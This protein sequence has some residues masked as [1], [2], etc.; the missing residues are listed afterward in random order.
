MEACIPHLLGLGFIVNQTVAYHPGHRQSYL[1][2]KVENA[3]GWRQS[4]VPLSALSK[5]PQAFGSE[6]TYQRRY[7]L[8]ALMGIA[9]DDDDGNA[10]ADAH[11]EQGER[12]AKRERRENREPRQDR[13]RQN[14]T[15]QSAQREPPPEDPMRVLAK[16]IRS[17]LLTAKSKADL[18]M[19]ADH[20]DVRAD[21]QRVL[22][23]DKRLH[24]WLVGEIDA[25]GAKLPAQ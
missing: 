6:L 3:N 10:A 16:R 21:M 22:D 13:Q 17:H 7:C 1:V 9:A 24:A 12:Q 19:M 8:G 18:E 5:G 14:Q 23:A 4:C 11:R 25:H 15:N 20:P 2:T